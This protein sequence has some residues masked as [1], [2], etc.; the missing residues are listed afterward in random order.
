MPCVWPFAWQ[1]AHSAGGFC[2]SSALVRRA[3]RR[4]ADRAVLL[5]RGML[6]DPRTALVGVAGEAQVADGLVRQARLLQRTV[7]VVAV[8]AEDLAFDDRVVRG[9]EYLA[10]DVAVA[11]D[12]PL[13]DELA[14]GRR[15]RRGRELRTP[16]LLVVARRLRAVDRVA[17]RRTSRR[18]CGAWRSDQ[19]SSCPLAAVAVEAH[20]RLFG[21]GRRSWTS[22]AL[23]GLDL[24]RVLQVRASRRR[25]RLWHALP[26]ASFCAPCAVSRIDAVCLSW[27][28]TQTGTASRGLLPLRNG[29][30]REER[31][32]RGHQPACD[33][34]VLG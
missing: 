16:D 32:E 31:C 6:V 11:L 23:V 4:V 1:S 22:S 14:H 24:G 5:D 17:V 28:L 33:L 30:Q 20:R 8:L 15:V 7:R 29:R 2:A 10:A 12:A 34:E 27:Q 9:L 18:P 19:C 25:G 13:V 26:F 3:V 21:R